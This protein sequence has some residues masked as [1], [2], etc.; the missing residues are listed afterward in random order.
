MSNSDDNSYTFERIRSAGGSATKGR[1]AST[2]SRG[3]S[4]VLFRPWVEYT[5][6]ATTTQTM[7]QWAK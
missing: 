3:T 6:T 5:L 4:C 2:T 1:P 7:Q